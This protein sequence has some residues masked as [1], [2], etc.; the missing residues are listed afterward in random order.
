VVVV[1]ELPGNCHRR[2]ESAIRQFLGTLDGEIRRL[3]GV[4]P[5]GVAA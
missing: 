3:Y 4:A 5:S 2:P 1:V